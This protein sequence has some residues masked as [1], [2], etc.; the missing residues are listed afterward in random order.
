MGRKERR[1]AAAG[2]GDAGLVF[3]PAELA[4]KLFYCFMRRKDVRVDVDSYSL[5]NSEVVFRWGLATVGVRWLI[6]ISKFYR[7][8]LVD[9][10][11]KEKSERR[12]A[13]VM[14]QNQG[15]LF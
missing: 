12:G 7:L 4:P 1:T 6:N 11:M 10:P 2:A 3:P 13:V 15:V 14:V 5:E 9:N 8:F